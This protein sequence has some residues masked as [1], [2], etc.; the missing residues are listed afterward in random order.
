M[1]LSV[2]TGRV[3]LAV[4]TSAACTRAV[5]V[6]GLVMCA[7]SRCLGL[8]KCNLRDVVSECNR[9]TQDGLDLVIDYG[10]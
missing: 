10:L 7:V 4:I 8:I 3:T 5:M 2:C 6:G 1:R 9:A